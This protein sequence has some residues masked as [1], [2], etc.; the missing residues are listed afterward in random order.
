MTTRLKAAPRQKPKVTFPTTAEGWCHWWTMLDLAWATP[1]TSPL[2]H[3]ARCS[4]HGPA[5][6]RRT[7]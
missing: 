7:A 6:L 1:T 5:H 4:I 2:H 3:N